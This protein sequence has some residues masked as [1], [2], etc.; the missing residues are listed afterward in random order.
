[1]E[2]GRPTLLI[3]LAPRVLGGALERVL[4]ERGFRVIVLDDEPDREALIAR[5]YDV[6]LRDEAADPRLQADIMIQVSVSAGTVDVTLPGGSCQPL[7]SVGEMLEYIA[8]GHPV[9]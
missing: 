5:R 9:T 6:I 3:A 4:R 1:M 2:A 8:A 7:G